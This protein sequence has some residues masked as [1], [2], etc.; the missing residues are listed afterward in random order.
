VVEGAAKI[1][2]GR[3]IKQSGAQWV[4]KHLDE[5]AELSRLKIRRSIVS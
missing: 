5:M 2:V 3:R 4:V 1:R